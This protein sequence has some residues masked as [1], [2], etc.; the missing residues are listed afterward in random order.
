MAVHLEL[1]ILVCDRL[2]IETYRRYGRHHL[3]NLQSV[4]NCG[5]AYSARI[6]VGRSLDKMFA[7][8]M[9]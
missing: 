2:D 9:R 7:V 1:N 8:R 6:S 3:S 4:K 5:F